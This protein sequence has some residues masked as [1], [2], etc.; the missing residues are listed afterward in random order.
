MIKISKII[1]AVCKVVQVEETPIRK[2]VRE[3][4]KA[5]LQFIVLKVVPKKFSKQ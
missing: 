1:T 5:S 2:R 4:E 3:S